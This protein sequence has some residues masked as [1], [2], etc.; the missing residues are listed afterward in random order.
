LQGEPHLATWGGAAVITF[1]VSAEVK[2]DP[3]LVLM[4]PS[5]VPTGKAELV[6]TVNPQSTG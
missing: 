1:R 5:N 3:Q 4:L 6:V 2:D